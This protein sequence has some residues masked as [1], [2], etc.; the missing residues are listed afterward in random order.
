[1]TYNVKLYSE[2][3]PGSRFDIM[4]HWDLERVGDVDTLGWDST[5]VSPLRVH[6]LL[7][8]PVTITS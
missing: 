8:T 2:H 7:K 1:M 4:V 6:H 5:V 3:T